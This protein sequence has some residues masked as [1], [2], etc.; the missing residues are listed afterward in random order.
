M[1]IR[2]KRHTSKQVCYLCSQCAVS[3][4]KERERERMANVIRS[5]SSSAVRLPTSL[6]RCLAKLLPKVVNPAFGTSPASPVEA[7]VVIKATN[8]PHP[9]H[10]PQQLTMRQCYKSPHSTARCVASGR[11]RDFCTQTKNN[12]IPSECTDRLQAF[13]NGLLP[14]PSRSTPSQNQHDEL[15]VL[16]LPLYTH[17]HTPTGH[18]APFTAVPHPFILP[19]FWGHLQPKNS[20]RNTQ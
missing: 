14:L 5:Q 11:G 10:H 20:I 4:N 3:I 8:P 13:C 9:H 7:T 16:L 18:V 17:T 6:A 1:Y 19:I 15:Y 2:N 12:P